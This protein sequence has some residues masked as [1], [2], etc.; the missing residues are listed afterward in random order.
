ML[1]LRLGVV[2]KKKKRRRKEGKK[3][4][5]CGPRG[6][7]HDWAIA[8]MSLSW[9]RDLLRPTC[10]YLFWLKS[11]FFFQNPKSLLLNDSTMVEALVRAFTPWKLANTADQGFAFFP[12]EPAVKHLPMQ[13]AP[14]PFITSKIILSVLRGLASCAH[15][16]ASPSEWP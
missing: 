12:G 1:Q 5:F 14:A 6:S 4:D 15:V 16:C 13:G 2:K 9:T 10:A 8:S 3:K 7:R 11:H